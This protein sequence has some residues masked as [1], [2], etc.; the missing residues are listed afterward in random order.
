MMEH[1]G[2]VSAGFS[3]RARCALWICVSYSERSE[4]LLSSFTKPILSCL[5]I[6]SGTWWILRLFLR[7]WF[8]K[9]SLWLAS[10]ILHLSKYLS[11]LSFLWLTSA[12]ALIQPSDPSIHFSNMAMRFSNP[13]PIFPVLTD[14]DKFQ[15]VKLSL[16]LGICIAKSL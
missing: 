2:S 15:L 3:P 13:P 7:R 11:T 4:V 5:L 12:A 1:G 10:V 14:R 9:L 6:P 16:S 8:C